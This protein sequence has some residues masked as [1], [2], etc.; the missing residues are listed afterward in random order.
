MNRRLTGC[1]GKAA[2]PAALR[3][4]ILIA[5][6]L[7]LQACA[8]PR[9]TGV[10]EPGVA[11]VSRDAAFYRQAA[12]EGATVYVV[13]AAS[14]RLWLR[15]RRGGPLAG[16]GHD[17]V[18]AA[19]AVAGY[20]L[21]PDAARAGRADLTIDLRR[22]A[23]DSP[24]L[25]REAGLGEPLSEAAIA[26]TRRNM[27]EKVLE[28]TRFPLLRVIATSP[29]GEAPPAALTITLV[30]HGVSRE[31]RLPIRLERTLDTVR[32]DGELVI[33]QREFGITPF[34]VLGGALRV[35]DRL[36]VTFRIMARRWQG[37]G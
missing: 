32:I 6:V 23:V 9:P 25:R 18:V 20:V 13:D 5:C 11:P 19:P 2:G 31:Y 37:E 7:A 12:Q 33:A 3:W 8:P 4:G 10:V 34:S 14:S 17:H 24:A 22:L 15:V 30:L 36:P 35:E 16:L 1:R 29:A 26:G 28:I 27:E 21:W